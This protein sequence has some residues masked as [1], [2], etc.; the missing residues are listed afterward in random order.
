MK[1]RR[2]I[3]AS[4][5]LNSLFL[6]HDHFS[7]IWLYNISL[8][9]DINLNV[10]FSPGYSSS[11][12]VNTIGICVGN[13]PDRVCVCLCRPTTCGWD[14][15]NKTSASHTLRKRWIKRDNVWYK[16]KMTSD[17]NFVDIIKTQ[18]HSICQQ[19][20]YYNGEP[21]ILHIS[22]WYISIIWNTTHTYDIPYFL[23]S[24]GHHKEK[25]FFF[26]F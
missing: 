24:R 2:C 8:G 10:N 18:K 14:N 13:N 25:G 3:F 9:L 6:Q 15:K 21:L 16:L 5:L 17:G 11:H 22:N 23:R 26:F 20:V 12:S 1:N 19:R 4:K 7:S